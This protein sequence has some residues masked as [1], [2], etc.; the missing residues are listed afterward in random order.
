[1]GLLCSLRG[2]KADAQS[3]VWNGGICFGKCT[4]CGADLVRTI[5][6]RWQVPRGYKVVWRAKS[7]REP[8]PVA[9][10]TAEL[11]GPLPDPLDWEGSWEPAQTSFEEAAAPADEELERELHGGQA[12]GPEELENPAE[13]SS[14]GTEVSDRVEWP[15]GASAG[16]QEDETEVEP[17]L[18]LQPSVEADAV[19]E[20]AIAE[21]PADDDALPDVAD[22]MDDGADDLDWADFPL[23]SQRSAAS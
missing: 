8:Q 18:K 16:E 9:S 11:P 21:R 13:V 7:E 6:D 20:G 15:L 4:R 1:M 23:P 3:A 10:E 12:V 5:K 14:V 22:F 17:D 2:H 19:V